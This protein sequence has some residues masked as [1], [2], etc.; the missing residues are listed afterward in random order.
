MTF[1][2][3]LLRPLTLLRKPVDNDGRFVFISPHSPYTFWS[4]HKWVLATVDRWLTDVS[5]RQVRPAELLSR[6]Q[7]HEMIKVFC[8]QVEH[9]IGSNMAE[10]ATY[11]APGSPV[12]DAIKTL[13]QRLHPRLFGAYLGNQLRQTVRQFPQIIDVINLTELFSRLEADLGL[14]QRP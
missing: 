6:E 14:L 8:E 7:A 1:R 13:K 10:Y 3:N 11:N 12:D 5:R 9:R 2:I 4:V